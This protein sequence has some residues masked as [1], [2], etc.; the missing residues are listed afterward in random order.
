MPHS[1]DRYLASL[2]VLLGSGWRDDQ[3]PGKMFADCIQLRTP[4]A[5]A[6]ELLEVDEALE[7]AL[8]AHRPAAVGLDLVPPSPSPWQLKFGRKRAAHKNQLQ[9]FVEEARAECLRR[10]GFCPAVPVAVGESLQLPPSVV[11]LSYR[12]SVTLTDPD[13]DIIR[14]GLLRSMLAHVP[15]ELEVDD[16]ANWGALH[17]DP[18]ESHRLVELRATLADWM[19]QGVS[20]ADLDPRAVNRSATLALLQ[21]RLTEDGTLRAWQLPPRLEQS[22]LAHS[23]LWRSSQELH[24]AVPADCTVV[25]CASEAGRRACRAASRDRQPSLTCLS[26]ELLPDHIEVELHPGC[27]RT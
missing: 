7:V 5:P 10:F 23:D 8:Q 24:A 12:H 6:A 18:P 20:L 2:D 25:L 3:A 14:S 4:S 22:M 19:R 26:W 9:S 1:D 13:L 16:V 15:D 27:E 11:Q 21:H 17:D